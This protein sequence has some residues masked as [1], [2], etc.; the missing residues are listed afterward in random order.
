[1]KKEDHSNGDYIPVA[2][3][4]HKK[5]NEKGKF[6]FIFIFYTKTTGT[7]YNCQ[8]KHMTCYIHTCWYWDSKERDAITK[9]DKDRFQYESSSSIVRESGINAIGNGGN[10]FFSGRR[11]Q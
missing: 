9:E 3:C 11:L 6:F 8:K 10:V 4:H 5:K 7:D 1:M 2:T